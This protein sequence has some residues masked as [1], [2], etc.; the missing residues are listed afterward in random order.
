MRKTLLAISLSLLGAG[1]ASAATGGPQRDVGKAS[2]YYWLHPKLGMVKVDRA[3][4]AMVT[5]RMPRPAP[6]E[7]DGRGTPQH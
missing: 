3:T 5:A 2:Y 1:F 6:I 7:S 4:N